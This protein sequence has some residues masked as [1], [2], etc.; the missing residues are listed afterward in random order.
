M[1][2]GDLVIYHGG[3]QCPSDVGIVI[4]V[5]STRCLVHWSS[6]SRPLYFSP[7]DLKLFPNDFSL[8]EEKK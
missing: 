3:H 5:R 8:I 4:E 7:Y 6:E 1:K 2:V